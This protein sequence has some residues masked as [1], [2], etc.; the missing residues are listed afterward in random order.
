MH[1]RYDFDAI[2]LCTGIFDNLK[3]ISMRMAF[4]AL[5][6]LASFTAVAAEPVAFPAKAKVSVDANGQLVAIDVLTDLP[7]QVEA[8]IKKRIA[9]WTFSPPKRGDV[10]GEG[11]TY[12]TLGACALPVDGGGYRLALDFKHNGPDLIGGA[13]PRY[14]LPDLHRKHEAKLVAK[15]IVKPDGRAKLQSLEYIEGR[16]YGAESF[17]ASI[18]TWVGTLHFAPEEIRG[19]PVATQVKISVDFVGNSAEETPSQISDK[20]ARS[21]ECRMAASDDRV[22]KQLAVD[23]PIQ[24]KPSG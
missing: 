12:L 15:V 22:I 6:I 8:F 16:N 11:V 24:V 20:V 19:K 17:D 1:W 9:S 21:D 4:L 2:P 13:M 5:A 7:P 18:R 3:E 14:P 23:S 10:T